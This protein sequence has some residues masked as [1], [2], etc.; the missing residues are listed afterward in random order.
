MRMAKHRIARRVGFEKCLIPW[1]ELIEDYFVRLSC[2]NCGFGQISAHTY[3][4]LS[5]K[6]DLVIRNAH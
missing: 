6:R 2:Q 3:S 4:F 5:Q 1:K